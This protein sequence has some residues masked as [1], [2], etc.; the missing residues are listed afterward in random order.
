MS[1]SKKDMPSLDEL[2]GMELVKPVDAEGQQPFPPR[3]PNVMPSPQRPM[4]PTAVSSSMSL[5]ECPTNIDKTTPLGKALLIAAGNP[6]DYE[7]DKQGVVRI[8]ATHWLVY[9]DSGHDEETGEVREFARTV[10]FDASG[11]HYR[12]TAAHGPSR[13]AAT[14]SLFDSEQWRRGIPFVVS[15]R[16]GKR[17]R[18]YHDIRLDSEKLIAMY[19]PDGS[20]TAGQP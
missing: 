20:V 5:A 17:G 4:L 14:L 12:T 1:K 3:H 6:S 19:K 11:K 7:P 18:T 16:M 2:M 9:P 10:L 8:L 15:Q 13:L